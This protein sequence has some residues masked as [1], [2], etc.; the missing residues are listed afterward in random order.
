MCYRD[1]FGL[2]RLKIRTMIPYFCVDIFSPDQI[3]KINPAFY[4]LFDISQNSE[5]GAVL[6]TLMMMIV[7][8]LKA[9]S[10]CPDLCEE[11]RSSL[12]DKYM[13]TFEKSIKVGGQGFQEIQNII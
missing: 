13:E 12:K 4:L 2:N 10:V 7:L 5:F 11:S 1:N 6:P 8:M 3:K 9:L